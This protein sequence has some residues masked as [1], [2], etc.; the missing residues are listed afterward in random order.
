MW[1]F[2]LGQLNIILYITEN[3]GGAG[4]VVVQNTSCQ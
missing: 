3:L 1:V 4:V 2:E